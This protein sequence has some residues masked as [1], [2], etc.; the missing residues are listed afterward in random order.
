[1][2]NGSICFTKGK[3]DR[4]PHGFV[5]FNRIKEN[6]NE[7]KVDV[8]TYK[9]MLF[10]NDCPVLSLKIVKTHT[11]RLTHLKRHY[12]QTTAGKSRYT[13]I[14]YLSSQ[15]IQTLIYCISSHS[16]VFLEQI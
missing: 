9:K 10:N 4:I 6:K 3:T 1:M 11:E 15:S 14:I 13:F 12:K 8:V 2:V 7:Q 5:Y 16:Y